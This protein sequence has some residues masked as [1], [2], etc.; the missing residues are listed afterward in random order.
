MPLRS[1]DKRKKQAPIEEDRS[2]PDIV[3]YSS[4]FCGQCWWTKLYLNRHQV[5]FQEVDID[6][7]PEA[8]RKVIAIT[9]GF[10]SVP[11][12]VIEGHGAIVEPTTGELASIMGID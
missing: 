5:P 9:G 12:L 10:R 6:R 1:W 3:L 11:M 7:D 2:W 8:A 4:K